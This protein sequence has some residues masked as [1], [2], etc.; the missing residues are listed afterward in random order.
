MTESCCLLC[1]VLGKRYVLGFEQC[2]F[3]YPLQWLLLVK[4]NMVPKI[5]GPPSICE[6]V[7]YNFFLHLSVC[8]LRKGSSLIGMD[9]NTKDLQTCSELRTKKSAFF[10]NYLRSL[11]VCIRYLFQVNPA[12]ITCSQMVLLLILVQEYLCSAPFWTHTCN[13]VKGKK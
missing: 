9:T 8:R 13:R 12:Y 1:D 2:T 10:W 6:G 3:S 7:K 11:R 5:S 4:A